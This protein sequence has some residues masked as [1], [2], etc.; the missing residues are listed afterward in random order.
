M[1]QNRKEVSANLFAS[2][3][4]VLK[5]GGVKRACLQSRLEGDLRLAL[6]G[7]RPN[8]EPF[9]LV[10]LGEEAHDAKDA[11]LQNWKRFVFCVRSSVWTQDEYV[12]A[13]NVA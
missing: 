2:G 7:S 8:K 4:S 13:I 6:S 3:S 9:L 12:C 1:G 5:R 10:S 11:N